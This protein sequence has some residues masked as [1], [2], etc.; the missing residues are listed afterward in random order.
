MS[1][2]YLWFISMMRRVGVGSGLLLA[3]GLL[4]IQ[5]QA[6]STIQAAPRWDSSAAMLSN[7]RNLQHAARLPTAHGA[8][9]TTLSPQ[10]LIPNSTVL[11]GS[12]FTL[13]VTLHANAYAV[14]ATAFSIDYDETWLTF[15]STDGNGDG[16]PDALRFRGPAAFSLSVM[17]DNTDVDGEI[18]VVIA[19]LLPPISALPDGIM[20]EL[21]LR[22]GSPPVPVDAPVKF[23]SAPALS[24]GTTTGQSIPAP[25]GGVDG[26]V[27]LLSEPVITASPTATALPTL[28][29]VTPTATATV[30]PTPSPSPTPTASATGAPTPTADV[31]IS[32]VSPDRGGTLLP[33]E[34]TIMGRNFADGAVVILGTNPAT[35]LATLYIS[36]DYLRATVPAGLAPGRYDLTVRNPNGKQA[37][38]VAAYQ[39]VDQT[40][41]D[42]LYGQ[43]TTFWSEPTTPR[44]QSV[45]QLGLVVYRQGGRTPLANVTVQFYAG[46]PDAGG[47]LIGTGAIPLLSPRST[48][49]TSAVTW[50]PPAAGDYTVFAVIDPENAVAEGDETN[51]RVGRSLTVLAAT[52]D[53]LAPHVDTFA[54]NNGAISTT[55]RSAFLDT[56]ASDPSLPPP[57]SGMGALFFVE[58]EYSPSAALWAPVQNSG[59]LPYGDA[60]ARLAWQ[61][62]PGAGMKYLQAWAADQAGNISVFPA[63][64]LINYL[65]PTD[66]VLQQQTRIYRYALTAGQ[67][68]QVRLVPTQGD[69][70][71]YIWP[72]DYTTRPP[73]VSNLAGEGVVDEIALVAP[74]TG[75]YQVEVYGYSAAAYQLVIMTDTE[76]EGAT[77]GVHATALNLADKPLFTQ[78]TLA[79][80]DRPTRYQSLPTVP[81]QLLNPQVYLPLIT[82]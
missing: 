76:Q 17:V 1:D 54:V 18:D 82:R 6:A 13:P 39:V 31:V 65:P 9:S 7:T 57:S 12:T 80:E 5:A 74:V 47:T 34:V 64:T 72:P 33:N 41:N 20:V 56:T 27:H 46:D 66:R 61:L 26:V 55:V 14:A 23:A 79:L 44:A 78:P 16:V 50:T 68:L 15:D 53:T 21:T 51:N 73:W 36:A 32:A 8:G 45:V 28:P 62:M 11:A 29:P 59:W 60:H 30:S 48:A 75:I 49:S 77:A 25:F 71:L 24:F 2:F 22:A 37:A 19:D 4:S 52:P 63:Q 38:L 35:S 70:D 10:L 81:A 40:L 3:L 67:A 69:P 42:D 43:A 58:Y